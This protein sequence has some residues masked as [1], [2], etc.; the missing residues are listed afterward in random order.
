MKQL[1]NGI[2]M[3]RYQITRGAGVK[4]IK[5]LIIKVWQF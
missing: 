1:S 5:T 2:Q 4:T 3:S